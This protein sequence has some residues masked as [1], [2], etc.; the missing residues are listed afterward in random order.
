[1]LNN[2]THHIQEHHFVLMENHLQ[3]LELLLPLSGGGLR[4]ALDHCGPLG[5]HRGVEG[6]RPNMKSRTT[7][8][9]SSMS[10]CAL[11]HCRHL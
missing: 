5:R 11:R 10:N 9:S 8:L 4:V 6:M 2:D 3:S 7:V 1:M